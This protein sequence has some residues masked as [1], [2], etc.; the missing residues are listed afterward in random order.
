MLFNVFCKNTKKV[1]IDFQNNCSARRGNNLFFCFGLREGTTIK[2]A[3]IVPP[4][5]EA[6]FIDTRLPKTLRGTQI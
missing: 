5:P 3:P 6:T 1:D 2:Y 4:M